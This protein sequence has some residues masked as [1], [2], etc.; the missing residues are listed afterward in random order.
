VTGRPSAAAGPARRF[1][2]PVAL[3]LVACAAPQ[4]TL[5]PAGSERLAGRL[6]VNVAA[7][8]GAQARAMSASFE[9]QGNARQG[10]L[11]L[12]TPLGTLAA[13]AQ[14]SPGAVRLA[15]PQGESHFESLETLT[16]EALGESI[17]VAALFDWLRGRPWPGAASLATT[18]PDDA[19]FRQLGWTVSLAKFDE[20]LVEARRDTPPAVTV[21][22]K[23]D[24]P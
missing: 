8:A 23:L 5:G 12:T 2:W 7:E 1:V 6:A 13:L 3:L 17:P 20:A 22:I 4:S 11:R 9:L 14:W 19:G 10:L 24:R 16:R 18:P 15:T 21:R